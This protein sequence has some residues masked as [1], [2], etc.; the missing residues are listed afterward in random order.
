MMRG[1]DI[2]NWQGGI[3]LLS[4]L[5][6][7]DFV[8]CKATGGTGFV[9]DYC[10]GWIQQCKEN[11]K[12]WGFYHFG[13]DWGYAP[14]YDEANFFIE[15]CWDYFGHGIPILD[16]ERD[17]IDDEWVN[18]FVNIVHSET[19]IWP[20]I[21]ANAWRITPNTEQNCGRWVASYPSQ[22]LYPDLHVELPEPPEVNGLL[23]AWQFA[24][25]CRIPGY[26][27]NL[28]A[29]VFYGDRTAWEKYAGCYNPP[30][31]E[32]QPHPEIDILE[33]E[34]YKV[35]IERKS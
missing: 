2:S 1:I 10:D 4:I 5:P 13:H 28:D 17:S 9:D 29:S 24:S 8:I 30:I 26:D 3:D 15:N 33:N 18:V 27:G 32:P 25:D 12:L 6:Q 14:A 34:H 35:T 22:L 7:T 31:P 11:D 23:C 20:W 16:W 19:G 21:Y